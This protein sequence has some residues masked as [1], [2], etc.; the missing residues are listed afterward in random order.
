[1]EKY[2][3]AEN[4]IFMPGNT[5]PQHS[6]WLSFSG[7]SVTLDGEQRYLDSHLAY[8]RACLHAIEYLTTFGWPK[9]ER[10]GYSGGS[11][12]DEGVGRATRAVPATQAGPAHP[13]RGGRR[14]Q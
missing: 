4:A 13:R 12:P 8:Q 10:G 2:N 6:Q 3:V 7:T 1:M 5:A 14:R 11:P 9:V